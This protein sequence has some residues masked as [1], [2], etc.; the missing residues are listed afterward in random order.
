M[1]KKVDVIAGKFVK[2]EDSQYEAESH[3]VDCLIEYFR[4]NGYRPSEALQACINGIVAIANTIEMTKDDAMQ[5][6]DFLREMVEE[7]W[8]AS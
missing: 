3:R 7:S 8:G 1:K 6:V 2:K 5:V 4:L